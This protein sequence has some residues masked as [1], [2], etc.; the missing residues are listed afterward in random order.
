MPLNIT[1]RAL[2]IWSARGDVV[3]S[4]CAG[5]GS[6]GWEALRA[7]R[8]FVGCELNATYYGAA[9]ANLNEAEATATSGDLFEVA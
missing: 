9:V 1:R 4:P 8:K 3:F 6:E 7:G 2:Q 5:I